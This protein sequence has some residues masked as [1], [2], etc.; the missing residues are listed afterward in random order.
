MPYVRERIYAPC[1]PRARWPDRA[2][3]AAI[4]ALPSDDPAAAKSGR[5]LSQSRCQHSWNSRSPSLAAAGGMGHARW[6]NFD[7]RN[8]QM[9]Q[10]RWQWRGFV[11]EGH[12]PPPV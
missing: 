2:G 10:M 5:Q 6:L 9:A 1:S 12:V 8:P 7:G 4:Q 11:G 3:K